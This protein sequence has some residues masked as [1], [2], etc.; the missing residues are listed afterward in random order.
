[1]VVWFQKETSSITGPRHEKKKILWT[2]YEYKAKVKKYEKQN[3]EAKTENRS[4]HVFG[5]AGIVGSVSYCL[6][7]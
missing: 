4:Q 5:E 1:M 7:I 2:W 6:Q 3:E